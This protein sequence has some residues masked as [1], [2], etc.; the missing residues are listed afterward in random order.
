MGFGSL[1]GGTFLAFLSQ[2]VERKYQVVKGIYLPSGS[3]QEIINQ[4][5]INNHYLYYVCWLKDWVLNSII[6][7]KK[8][9]NRSSI[10]T[11]CF[12]ENKTYA[13]NTCI[14]NQYVQSEQLLNN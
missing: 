4:L 12:T 11:F 8:F 6:D 7:Y 1:R 13:T 9:S 14:P 2:A 10:K 5:I 3:H